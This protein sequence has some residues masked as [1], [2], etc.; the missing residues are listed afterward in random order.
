MNNSKQPRSAISIGVS[1]WIMAILAMV[2]MGGDFGRIINDS[3]LSV[4]NP[5]QVLYTGLIMWIGIV[6]TDAIVSHGVCVYYNGKVNSMAKWSSI[7]RYIY[8]GIL[9][10]AV[11]K[12]Y[13]ATQSNLEEERNAL[14]HQFESIW[15]IGL[16]VFGVHLILLSK[17][18]GKTDRWISITRVLLLIAGIGYSLSNTLDLFIPN[19]EE[20]RIWVE[21]PFILPMI[22]GELSWGLWLILRGRSIALAID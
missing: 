17:I 16:I 18:V 9:A 1:I 20:L 8:T 10:V 13:S 12:I 4:I 2:S 11:W 21:L 14:L 5:Q 22:V 15:Q 6:I 3:T 19:Y 7:A